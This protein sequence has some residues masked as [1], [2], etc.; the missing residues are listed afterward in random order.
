MTTSRRGGGGASRTKTTFSARGGSA[1]TTTGG[2]GV[3]TTT[4]ARPRPGAATQPASDH[5]RTP[6]PSS[7]IS[8]IH[9]RREK[10]ELAVMIEKNSGYMPSVT[11]AHEAAFLYRTV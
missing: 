5:N 6:Q 2:G 1:T 8:A 7:R 3:L 4:A 10:R 11:E 9:S